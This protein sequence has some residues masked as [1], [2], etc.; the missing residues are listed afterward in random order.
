MTEMFDDYKIIKDELW[1]RFNR[2]KE[3]QYW[4]YLEFYKIFN[5]NELI[6]KEHLKRI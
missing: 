4:Y 5:Y 3:K 6:D 2:G 1:E